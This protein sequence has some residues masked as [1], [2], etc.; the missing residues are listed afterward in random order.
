ML[1]ADLARGLWYQKCYDH[2]CKKID[3]RGS[4]K[5]IP[6]HLCPFIEISKGNPDATSSS[7]DPEDLIEEAETCGIWLTDEELLK[8][9]M[10][11]T[12]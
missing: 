3:F 4:E 6:F 1:V 12:T 5:D 10:N 7:T 8:I 9:D 11:P 2:Q